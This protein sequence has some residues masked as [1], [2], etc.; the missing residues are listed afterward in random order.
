MAVG[1]GHLLVRLFRGGIKR[2][3]MIC[4]V[5]LAKWDLRVGPIDRGCRCQQGV[6]RRR[7]AHQFQKIK[8]SG[9]IGVE[10]GARIV[11]AIA[12]SRLRREMENRIESGAINPL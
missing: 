7:M 1:M 12:H 6:R 4:L 2:Q 11:E 8:G 3:R 10:I 5:D 9:E